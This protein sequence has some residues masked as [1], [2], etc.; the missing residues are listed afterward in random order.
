ME[1]SS[2]FWLKAK[3]E[4]K[5]QTCWRAGEQQQQVQDKGQQE[6][7]VWAGMLQLPLE[8][9]LQ[10][11]FPCKLRGRIQALV[12]VGSAR[13]NLEQLERSQ[14]NRTAWALAKEGDMGLQW[15]WRSFK[16]LV[17]VPLPRGGAVRSR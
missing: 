12:L 14:S 3:L 8:E 16:E 10:L 2:K 1:N 9:Q 13:S 17:L 15:D 6:Q 11:I 4:I 7:P 5:S